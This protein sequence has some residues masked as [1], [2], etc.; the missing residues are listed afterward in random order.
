MACRTNCSEFKIVYICF[1]AVGLQFKLGNLCVGGQR[2]WLQVVCNGGVAVVACILYLIE[3]GSGEQP[4]DFAQRYNASLFSIALLGSLACC[5][6]D[7]WA[8]EIGS[9]YGSYPRLVTTLQLV[10]VGTNGGITLIGTVASL[11]GGTIVGVVYYATI[12]AMMTFDMTL[13]NYPPQW[14]IILIGSLSG[15]IGSLI[16]SILGAKLQYSGYCHVQ[17]RIV[18]SPSS[19]T[20]DISGRDILSNHGVNFFSSLMTASIMPV[21]AYGL[22]KYM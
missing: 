13:E 19:T 18:H 17:K 16:D 9:V 8:S 7:T 1:I 21:I 22:W 6:G 12:Q 3:V 5:N 4:I 11:V 2:D 14:P 10:P 15:L 20:K